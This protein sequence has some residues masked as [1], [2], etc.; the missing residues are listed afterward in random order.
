[1]G[2]E[3]FDKLRPNLCGVTEPKLIM[4]FAHAAA[5]SERQ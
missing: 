1:M 4:S 5:D 3:G 2:R